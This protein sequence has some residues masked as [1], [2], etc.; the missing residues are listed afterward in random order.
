[1]HFE[2]LE[3]T[4]GDFDKY[5]DLKLYGKMKEIIIKTKMAND[6]IEAI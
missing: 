5:I 3:K 6:Y 4:L 1:M 2:I